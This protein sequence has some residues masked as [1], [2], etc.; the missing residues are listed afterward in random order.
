MNSFDV[1]VN[2]VKSVDKLNIVEF[3][4]KGEKLSMMSLELDEKVEVAK[5]VK[6]AFKSMSVGIAKEFDGFLSYS[7]QLKSSIVSIEVGELLSRVEL[8]FFDV[9]IEAIIT[10]KSLERME[11]KEGESV[12]VLIKA[13]ELYIEEIL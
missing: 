3:V 11:L 12:S 7:N 6:V 9:E 5:K 4:Y 13:S 10:T 2:S 8:S 1:E